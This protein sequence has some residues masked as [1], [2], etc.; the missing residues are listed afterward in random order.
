MTLLTTS[1]QDILS[2]GTIRYPRALANTE[3]ATAI[4]EQTVASLHDDLQRLGHTITDIA[5]V[6]TPIIARGARW[7]AIVETDNGDELIVT[8]RIGL[9]RRARYDVRHVP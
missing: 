7:H 3:P 9:R 4:R 5:V 1:R 6:G 8:C 2:R